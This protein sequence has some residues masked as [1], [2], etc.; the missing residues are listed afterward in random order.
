MTDEEMDIEWFEQRY[1]V[2]SEDFYRSHLADDL[3]VMSVD[4]THRH[5]WA[6]LIR[7]RAARARADWRREISRDFKYLDA[8]LTQTAESLHRLVL[9]D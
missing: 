3:W 1:V 5:E 7:S 8:T 9:V 6:E 4:R 2:T